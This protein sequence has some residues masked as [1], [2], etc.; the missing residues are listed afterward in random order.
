M[1][2]RMQSHKR[3]L[4]WW[5]RKRVQPP[6][7]KVQKFLTKL[8]RDFSH[9]SAITLL[10]IKP[11]DVKTYVHKKHFTLMFLPAFFMKVEAAKISFIGDQ[12]NKLWYN[13]TME[14]HSVIKTI[15]LHNNLDKS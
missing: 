1:S 2:V 8:N 4:C 3:L 15:N 10:G 5:K 13:I 6:W 12:L 14:Y 7:K 9:D 11:T